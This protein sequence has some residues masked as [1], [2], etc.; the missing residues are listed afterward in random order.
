MA[1][2]IAPP[3][4]LLIFFAQHNLSVGKME[5]QITQK[6]GLE[7]TSPLMN[8]VGALSPALPTGSLW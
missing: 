6:S 5:L 2:K 8:S 3:H 1:E 7:L 4:I